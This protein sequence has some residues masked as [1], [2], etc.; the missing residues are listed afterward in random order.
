MDWNIRSQITLEYVFTLAMGVIFFMALFAFFTGQFSGFNKEQRMDEITALAQSLKIEIDT[1]ESVH[2][3]YNRT[4]LL[5]SNI[6]GRSYTVVIQNHELTVKQDI[7]EYT[8]FL[9]D[10]QGNFTPGIP[11]TI[12]RINDRVIIT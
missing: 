11:N 7:Y 1:A 6:M 2:N 5:P 3:G 12:Q 9:P 4:I 10:V 8:V